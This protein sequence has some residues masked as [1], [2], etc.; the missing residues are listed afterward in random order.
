MIKNLLSA[1]AAPA[2]PWIII[3]CM[4]ALTM[5]GVAGMYGGYEI[6]SAR[7]AKERQDLLEAQIA[8]LSLAKDELAAAHRRSNEVSGEFL[9][10]LKDMKIVNT[11]INTEVKKETERLIYTDCKLPDSGTDLLRKR[12]DEV[13]SRLGSEPK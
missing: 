7:H 3:G 13:N 8:S 5:S 2:A 6:A 10:A 11:T 9:V 12:A 1:A 4:L